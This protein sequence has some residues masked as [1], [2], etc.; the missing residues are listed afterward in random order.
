MGFERLLGPVSVVVEEF[1]T[2]A[3]GVLGDQDHLGHLFDHYDL[4]HTVGRHSAVVHQPAI[5]ARLTGGVDTE[6]FFILETFLTE[7]RG[8]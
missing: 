5:P 8:L 4:G 6:I 7:F 3:D 2:G 1:L